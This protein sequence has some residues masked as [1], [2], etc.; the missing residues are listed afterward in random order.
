MTYAFL[1]PAAIAQIFSPI[2]EPVIPTGIPDK[3]AKVYLEKHPVIVEAKI[4]KFFK[5]RSNTL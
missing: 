1:I 5:I 3:E 4:R 2:A